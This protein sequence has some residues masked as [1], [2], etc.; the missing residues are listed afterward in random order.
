M[1]PSTRFDLATKINAADAGSGT[2]RRYNTA[3]IKNAKS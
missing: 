1:N 3:V 2:V